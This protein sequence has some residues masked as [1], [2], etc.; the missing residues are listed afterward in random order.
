MDTE[1]FPNTSLV[2]LSFFEQKGY[3]NIELKRECDALEQLYLP[4]NLRNNHND[5]C[6]Q[7]DGHSPS[8]FRDL[9]SELQ[10]PVQPHLPENAEE[11]QAARE[12]AAELIQ[13]AD[14]L[15]HR[16][17]SLAAER[18]SKNLRSSQEQNW[19]RYLSSGVQ[20]LLQQ[21]P[22]AREFQKELVEMAFTFVLMKSVCERTPNFLYGLYG[23]VTQ[24]F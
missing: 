2:L 13:I 11:I 14:L 17:L 18:L 8:A 9:L 24:Y 3:Q 19:G 23:I 16:V 12:M 15:E 21:V 4:T 20:A 5:E 1:H 22:R 6:L 10:H 7:T